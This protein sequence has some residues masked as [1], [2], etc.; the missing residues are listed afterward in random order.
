MAPLDFSEAC[1]ANSDCDIKAKKSKPVQREETISIRTN[2]RV[3]DEMI[4]AREGAF[5]VNRQ[6]LLQALW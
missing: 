4:V 3:S 1:A 6:R 5:N 2:K